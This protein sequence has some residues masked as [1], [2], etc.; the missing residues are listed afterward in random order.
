MKTF[1]GCTWAAPDSTAVEFFLRL[2][3]HFFNKVCFPVQ[4]PWH[5][6]A[7]LNNDNYRTRNSKMLITLF[8]ISMLRIRAWKSPPSIRQFLL[9]LLLVFPANADAADPVGKLTGGWRLAEESSPYLRMHQDNPVEW[10]PWGEEALARAKKENKPLMISIGYFTCHWC[11]VMERESFRNPEIARLLSDGFIS[12]KVDREQRPDL[13]AAYMTFVVATQGYGGWPMTVLATPDGTPFFG[14]TYFPPENRENA[15]GFA[16]LLRKARTLWEK[17]RQNIIETSRQAV[18]QIKQ[19]M[20]KNKPL[21]TLTNETVA[22]ARQLFRAQFDQHEG[23]FSLA[24]KFPQP[25]ELLFLL[26][27]DDAQSAEMA[28]FTLDRMAAGGIH[29]HVEGGFHRYATDPGWRVPHFEKML[30][31]QALIARAYLAAYRRTSNKKYADVAERILDFTMANMR[32]ARGGFHSA[33]GADSAV[34]AKAPHKMEEGAYYVWEWK[35]LREAIPDL[36]LR[37]WAI[38]YYDLKPEG[39]V[40]ESGVAELAGKNILYISRTAEELAK[41]FG[42]NLTTVHT[43]IRALNRLLF[44]ARRVRPAPPRDEKV[45]TAWNGYMVTALA[46]AGQLLNQPRYRQA[47]EK[48]A[49]FIL[50]VLYDEKPNLLYRD[51]RGGRRGVTG[52]AEDYAAMSEGLLALYNL[53]GN[54][55]WLAAAKNLTDT[56]IKL[57]WDDEDGGFYGADRNTGLWL[58]DKPAADN[59]TPSAS[60]MSVGNLLKL[61]SLTRVKS[62]TEMAVRTAAWQGGM[63]RDTPEA[64]PYTLAIWPILLAQTNR[65]EPV[66]TR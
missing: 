8:Q 66:I 36:V 1:V 29:D 9:G 30:Y 32:D 28:L 22:K 46:E 31:D 15:P 27:D 39:N 34:N 40:V 18:E 14:G 65:S 43:R 48:T 21:S 33:L 58:R 11:H 55:Q 61:G 62:Y 59:V 64:M 4:E 3:R 50:T 47:A 57:F 52:F 2:D 54:K 23:G 6:N 19:A 10:Y 16:P 12:I 38:A 37:K 26:Q 44:S 5:R 60:A 63:L 25:A 53:D 49:R 42:E 17:D 51:W 20:V 45:V 13:D 41:Q 35:Q 56:Q 24:P 7:I